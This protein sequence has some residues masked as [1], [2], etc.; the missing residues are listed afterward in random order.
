MPIDR[1]MF[2]KYL[3]KASVYFEFGGGGSTYQAAIKPNIQKVI[4]VESMKEWITTITT[5][6]KDT[7]KVEFIYIDIKND[8]CNGGWGHPSVKATP[9]DKVSY[10]NTIK[11][12]HDNAKIDLV[13]ID[14]RFRVACALKTFINVSDD[15]IIIFDD[16]L[17]RSQYHIILNYYEIIEKTI[18]NCMAVLRKKHVPPPSNELIQKYE[19]IAD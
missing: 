2:Y 7:S 16:F 11:Y 19:L 4:C 17:N 14:G 6:L 3:E 15:C 12:Y 13:L 5:Q 8:G 9:E 10:S 1:K 18:D